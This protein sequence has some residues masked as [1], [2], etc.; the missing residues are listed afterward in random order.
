MTRIA[1]LQDRLR[2]L[3]KRREGEGIYTDA[4]I[5]EEAAEALSRTGAVK[6]GLEQAAAIILAQIDSHPDWTPEQEAELRAHDP[7][8]TA[9]SAARV[10]IKQCHRAILSAL[11]PA[12]PEGHHPDD[13]AVDRFAAAMKEKLA[14]KR[15]EGRGGWDD[16]EKCSGEYLSRLLREHV[17]KG[18][19]VDVGNLAMMLHQRGERI[20]PEGQQDDDRIRREMEEI[21]RRQSERDI[22]FAPATRPAEQAVTEAMVEAANNAFLDTINSG[23]AVF[24]QA[25]LVGINFDVAMRAALKAALAQENKP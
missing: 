10:A 22:P 7:V 18:D 25:V 23:A 11:E 13:I 5:C 9:R 17:D 2:R 24:G 12:A 16:K 20:A 8:A 19:P 3:A 15:E 21:L 6:A 1:E 4:A 14:R